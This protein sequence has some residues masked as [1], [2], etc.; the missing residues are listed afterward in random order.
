[1]KI[2][3]FKVG[4]EVYVYSDR[5]L[6]LLKEREEQVYTVAKIGRKYL[7]AAKGKHN[8]VKSVPEYLLQCFREPEWTDEFLELNIDCGCKEIM[9]PDMEEAND[10]FEKRKLVRLFE[11]KVSWNQYKIDDL[12]KIKNILGV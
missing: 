8:N 1:M 3:D 10:C 2:K 9:F 5:D 6:M 11:T 7:Y 4:Q 12:R